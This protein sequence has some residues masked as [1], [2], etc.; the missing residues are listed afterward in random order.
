MSTLKEVADFLIRP[1]E[2]LS[3]RLLDALHELGKR[4]PCR[5]HQQMHMIGHQAERPDNH[6][7]LLPIRGESLQIG[8]IVGIAEE[9]GL[10]LIAS[11]ND[12]IEQP[13]RKHARTTSQGAADYVPRQVIVKI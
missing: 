9:R 5:F 2:V 6:V 4:W 13:C 11:H 8:L 1:I 7:I 12:V 10:S 3:I